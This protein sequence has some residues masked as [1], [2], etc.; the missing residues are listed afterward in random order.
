VQ[1]TKQINTWYK[2]GIKTQMASIDK[3][4]DALV[5]DGAMLSCFELGHAAA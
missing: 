4:Y 2:D 3:H 1:V 5:R